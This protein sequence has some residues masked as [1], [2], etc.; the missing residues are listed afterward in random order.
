MRFNTGN[1]V[2]PDGSS[3]PRDLYDTAGIVDLLVTGEE[4]STKDRLGRD[5]KSWKGIEN[6]FQQAQTQRGEEFALSQSEREAEFVEAQNDK[7]DR[8][9]QLMDNSQYEPMGNYAAGIEITSRNQI[10]WKDGEYYRIAAS[11]SIPYT[12]TGN[13][14]T[15]APKFVTVGDAALR[16]DLAAV[17]GSS[18]VTYQGLGGVARSLKSKLDDEIG[19]LDFA[20]G[21]GPTDNYTAVFSAFEALHQGLLVDLSG[22]TFIVDAVPSKNGYKNGFF[23][24]GGFT[25]PAMISNSFAAQPHHSHLFGG[26]L[27]A[28]FQGLSNPLEQMTGIVF[29]GDSQIWGSGNGTEQ[30]TTNPRDGTLSDA[31]DYFGTSSFVNI[32]KRYVGKTFARDAAPALSN[33]PTA[34]TGQSIATYTATNVLFPSDGDFT[35]VQAAG[36]S[37][38]TA[39]VATPVPI[40]YAQ[41]TMTNAN[42]AV[43]TGHTL[44]FNFT[45]TSFKLGFGCTEATATYYELVVGGVSQGLFSTHAGVDGFIDIT[46][47]NYRTH[48]F[49]YVRNALV[50]IK[51][52]RNGEAGTRI[53][54]LE[55]ITIDKVIRITNNGIN[56]AS[57][58]S[59]RASNLVGAPADG[60]AVLPDDNHVIIKIGTND[61]ISATSRPKGSNAF[62]AN[63]NLFIDAVKAISP[64]ANI[65]LCCSNPATEDPATYSFTMQ[66]VRSVTYQTAKAR[67]I[68]MVDGYAAFQS[69]TLVPGF[70]A[71]GLHLNQAGYEL[72]AR[73]FINSLEASSFSSAV[74]LTGRVADLEA[75]PRG[76]GDGQTWQ[77][78]TASRA[79]GTTY[80]NSTG[81]SITLSVYN[82]PSASGSFSLTVA[83]IVIGIF[84]T[85]NTTPGASGQLFGVV[86]PGA[87]YLV[88]VSGMT[89]GRWSELR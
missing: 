72:E 4:D 76:I 38:S 41:R 64:T 87:T 65:V 1:P 10:I 54:R 58:I 57:S 5:R 9:Q 26:Q 23:K 88:A 77:D 28:L 12:T 22:R 40:T 68:D 7:N 86:P 20:S 46:N 29:L 81:R 16:Q 27:A 13:W 56:G 19:P 35:L 37:I 32:I 31:R 34:P 11:A 59:Y 50:E 85:N 84:Q 79:A 17:D 48:T 63:Y 66:E 82:T 55:S 60:L 15:D 24:I 30:A 44:S 62:K 36:A 14:A 51:T 21:L 47:N 6:D 70:S 39:V 52:R 83:G 78:V 2:E 89:I 69:L 3:D 80:T 8:F 18:K 75:R 33:H 67:S 53:L 73:N 71:D 45:G 49:G 43:E 74:D 25:K 42:V 61:R